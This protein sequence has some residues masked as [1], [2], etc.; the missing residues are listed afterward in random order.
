MRV[1]FVAVTH[2]MLPAPMG[3][4]RYQRPGRSDTPSSSTRSS[5]DSLPSDSGTR[6]KRSA[7]AGPVTRTTSSGPSHTAVL[8]D[9]TSIAPVTCGTPPGT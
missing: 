1:F 8:P 9:V 2:Q 4:A 3:S 6:V 7:P 5:G